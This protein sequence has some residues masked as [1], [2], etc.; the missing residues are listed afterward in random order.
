LSA[1][2]QERKPQLGNNGEWSKC[3][4]SRYV[5]GLPGWP[6]AVILETRMY[7]LDVG[8]VEFGGGRRH[9]IKPAT[10]RIDQGERRPSMG[11][12]QWEAG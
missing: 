4:R 8:E 6:L 12:G 5:E 9:P 3:S 10:V 1:D 7:H 2:P 11:D